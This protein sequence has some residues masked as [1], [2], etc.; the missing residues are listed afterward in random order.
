VQLHFPRPYLAE[1]EIE[2]PAEAYEPLYRQKVRELRRELA[3]PGFRPGQVPIDLIMARHGEPILLEILSE[4]FL[5]ALHQGLEGRKLVG[6]PFYI[7]IPE[8]LQ[9]QP[10]FPTYRY[11]VKVLA[12]PPSPLPLDG[13]R[14]VRYTYEPHPDDIL[15]YQRHLKAAFGTLEPL[16]R[17]P[18]TPPADKELILRLRWEAPGT[19]EPLR[20]SWTTL[21]TPFPWSHLA[22]KK[23]GETFLVPPQALAP[24]TEI[25][26][27]ALPDFSPLSAADIPL[28]LVSAAQVQPMPL[29]ELKT[30]LDFAGLSDLSEEEI[31]K[32]LLERH[33][34]RLLE[35]LNNQARQAQILHAA[36]IQ[37][38]EDL[39]QYNYLLYLRQR[40]GQNGHLRAYEDYH[41]DLAWQVLFASYAYHEPELQISDEELHNLVWERLKASKNLSE[42]T[43]ALL[44]RIENS[45]ADREAFLQAFLENDREGWRR[46]LQ[47]ERFDAWLNQRLGPPQERPLPAKVLFLRML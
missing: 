29:E 19:P 28:T 12:V 32:G 37:L 23:V 36:G 2:I 44:R 25:I 8:A 15:L 9:V 42:D 4:R 35:K 26:R 31:W 24:Y 16:E 7:R 47:L 41:A 22:G 34:T 5:E 1:G 17:L 3:L 39:V 45:Q 40:S 33:V 14:L 38:P 10:P 20:L 21:L 11:T 30:Q 13:V 46:S 43:Q 6:Y 27:L 18:E